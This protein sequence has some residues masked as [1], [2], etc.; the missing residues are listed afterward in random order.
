MATVLDRAKADATIQV[1][2][3]Q[4]MKNLINT[5]AETVGKTLSTFVLESASQQAM[6]VL[7][8]QRVFNLNAEASEEF[9]SA[10]QAPAQPTSQLRELL[11]SKSPW[12]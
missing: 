7:L 11:A 9:A 6:D 3:P 1:R 5:A 2:L 12:E 4:H 8:D 10:L